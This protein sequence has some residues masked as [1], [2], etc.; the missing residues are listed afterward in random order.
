LFYNKTTAQ[1]EF[2]QPKD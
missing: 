1:R 2:A